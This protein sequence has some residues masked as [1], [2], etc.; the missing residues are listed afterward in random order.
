MYCCSQ[1]TEYN[2]I[3]RGMY[4]LLVSLVNGMFN[5]YDLTH[6]TFRE[7]IFLLITKSITPSDWILTEHMTLSLCN[8]GFLLLMTQN[9]Y[10]S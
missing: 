4:S 6:I 3:S 9:W 7:E 5:I 2:T 8:S 10:I 1:L